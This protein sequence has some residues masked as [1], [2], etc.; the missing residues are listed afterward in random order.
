[1][2]IIRL[3]CLPG[4]LGDPNSPAL[5][6]THPASTCLAEC[7][8]TPFEHFR[9]LG[10]ASCAS[11]LAPARYLPRRH[12]HAA[13]A[14][15]PLH[16]EAEA[17]LSLQLVVEISFC[18]F[19][20]VAEVNVEQSNCL[21]LVRLRARQLFIFRANRHSD[22]ATRLASRHAVEYKV[23]PDSKLADCKCGGCW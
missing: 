19:Q 21:D 5:S 18:H 15:R 7:Y 1:M 16:S 20:L 6:Q 13:G 9:E 4:W 23:L 22:G 12:I 17:R 10:A 8:V 14:T 2:A 11:H 3:L